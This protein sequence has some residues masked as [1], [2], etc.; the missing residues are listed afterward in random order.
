MSDITTEKEHFGSAELEYVKIV[1]T[2]QKLSE[3]LTKQ[4]FLSGA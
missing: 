3:H 4:P 1:R 2:F